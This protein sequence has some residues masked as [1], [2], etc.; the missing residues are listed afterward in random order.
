MEGGQFL[1][2][3]VGRPQGFYLVCELGSGFCSLGKFDLVV[4]EAMV[5]NILSHIHELVLKKA[6]CLNW[7]HHFKN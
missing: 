2:F 5:P 3:G 1:P 4:K 6:F 7:I